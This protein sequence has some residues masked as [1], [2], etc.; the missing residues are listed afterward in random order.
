M[1]AC[2]LTSAPGTSNPAISTRQIRIPL[3][4]QAHRNQPNLLDRFRRIPFS[5][6]PPPEN[7]RNTSLTPGSLIDSLELNRPELRTNLIVRSIAAPT[8]LVHPHETCSLVNC[9]PPGEKI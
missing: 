9:V 5:T 2:Q 6:A 1:P 8:R 3:K 4:H 7:H